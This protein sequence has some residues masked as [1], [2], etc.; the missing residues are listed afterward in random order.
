MQRT[1]VQ[2]V[3]QEDS[4]CLG[5]TKPTSHNYRVCLLQL[6]RAVCLE[7]VLRNKSSHRS[8]KPAHRIKGW[9]R[10]LQLQKARAQ[11]Q[12]PSAVKKKQISFFLFFFLKKDVST[13]PMLRLANEAKKM[14]PILQRRMVFQQGRNYYLPTS[15]LQRNHLWLFWF[16]VLRYYKRPHYPA[17]YING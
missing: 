12:R 15:T 7:P 9:P 16:R 6:L 5:A 17:K 2:S 1:R 4:T 3:A 8:E 13:P 10:S 14:K 11:W